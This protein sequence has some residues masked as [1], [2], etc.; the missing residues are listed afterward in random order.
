MSFN[1]FELPQEHLDRLRID[2]LERI[3]EVGGNAD[4]LG[5]DELLEIQAATEDVSDF[6]AGRMA[7]GA[8]LETGIAGLL[9]AAGFEDT[10]E[11]TMKSAEQTQEELALRYLSPA[12]GCRISRRC[13]RYISWWACRRSRNSHCS[14]H[15]NLCRL[16]HSAANGRA[17]HRL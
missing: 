5:L 16:Q 12:N 7:A 6:Q 10:A 3:Q 9:S 4:M 14:G 8:A 17:K 1:L 11:S 13:R 15:S 2:Q